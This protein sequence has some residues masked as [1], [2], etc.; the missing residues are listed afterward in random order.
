MNPLTFQ[1]G[2][3]FSNPPQVDCSVLHV[4]QSDGQL[5]GDGGRA[6]LQAVHVVFQFTG[7][8]KE[9]TNVV[10]SPPQRQTNYYCSS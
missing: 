5:A 10:K 6:G 7:N 4:P 2:K 8:W 3:S 1:D 9:M